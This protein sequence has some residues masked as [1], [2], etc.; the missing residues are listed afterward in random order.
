MPKDFIRQHLLLSLLIF[1]LL[2]SPNSIRAD[3]CPHAPLPRLRPGMIAAVAPEI[4]RLN[5][6]ALP[7]VST[8]VVDL[9][10][11]GDIMTVLSGPSCNGNYN[12]W[13]VELENGNRG[14]VAEGNWERFYVIPLRDQFAP[15]DPFEWSCPPRIATRHCLVP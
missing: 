3:A 5:L 4:N 8:G 13:R 15:P 2:T 10:G 11:S 1:G 14:W 9:L 6:R 12:W 7:A